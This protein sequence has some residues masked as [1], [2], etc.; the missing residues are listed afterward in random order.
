MPQLVDIGIVASG[1]QARLFVMSGQTAGPAVWIV[2]VRTFDLLI[3]PEVDQGWPS[4][5]AGT[6]GGRVAEREIDSSKWM[7]TRQVE[8]QVPA[9]TGYPGDVEAY[10][11]L[12][13]TQGSAHVAAQTRA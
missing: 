12:P 8:P 5:P 6:P 3:T 13:L 2:A 4:D 9:S 7:M 1:A 10:L 11:G